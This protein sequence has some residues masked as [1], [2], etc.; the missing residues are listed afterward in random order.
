MTLTL[1]SALGVII[2]LLLPDAV[3]TRLRTRY[4]VRLERGLPDG[5]DMMVICAEAGLGMGTALARVA[6]EMRPANPVVAEES[7][8][9]LAEMAV[10]N[11]RRQTLLNLGERTKL[12]TLKRFAATLVQALHDGTPLA[13][14][15]P[16]QDV[17]RYLDGPAPLYFVAA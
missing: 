3:V 9:T 16:A 13:S 15:L 4:L 11:D 7:R 2:G 12:D 10:L 14:A 5:L 17:A 8:L 1:V 6:E